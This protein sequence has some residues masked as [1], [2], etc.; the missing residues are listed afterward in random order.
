M[1]MERGI[2]E[3]KANSAKD[4]WE[5]NAHNTHFFEWKLSDSIG[6]FLPDSFEAIGGRDS[7]Y[8][9]HL[10]VIPL[11]H[12]QQEC[13]GRDEDLAYLHLL[14][15]KPDM[16]VAVEG[17]AGIGK[18]TLVKAYLTKNQHLYQHLV[19]IDYQKDL[20]Q[21]FVDDPHLLGLID[22]SER[23]DR[24]KA[25]GFF[26]I[27]KVLNTLS[28]P[29]LLVIDNNDT[30]FF[31]EYKQNLLPT[32]NG[33]KT[34]IISRETAH[35][36]TLKIEELESVPA[37][38]LFHRHYQNTE[39]TKIYELLA[40]A[41]FNPLKIKL[42]AQLLTRFQGWLSAQSLLTLKKI[43]FDSIA[44]YLQNY[45]DQANDAIQI[46]NW[47]A[48]GGEKELIEGAVSRYLD[49]NAEDKA[50]H[51]V[52]SAWLEANGSTKTIKNETQRYLNK[53]AIRIEAGVVLT[54]WLK[55]RGDLDIVL[56]AINKF[57][58]QHAESLYSTKV[59]EQWIMRDKNTEKIVKYLKKHLDKNANKQESF[60]VM[61][62]WLMNEGAPEVVKTYIK[63]YLDLYPTGANTAG[64]IIAWLGAE[65]DPEF[66]QDRLVKQLEQISEP[67]D[68]YLLVSVW[69]LA[70][71]SLNAVRG[72]I[73]TLM[74]LPP[75]ETFTSNMIQSWL[76]AG[77]E[78]KIVE[79]GM[80]S[81]LRKFPTEKET[82]SVISAWLDAGGDPN[83]VSKA[84][85]LYLEKNISQREA[86]LVMISLLK[87]GEPPKSLLG[88]IEAHLKVFPSGEKTNELLKIWI[89]KG[90]KRDI[91]EQIIAQEKK[92]TAQQIRNFVSR[93]ELKQA[94]DLLH[95]FVPS[96]KIDNVILLESKLAYVK[97]TSALL[98][99]N[100]EYIS[101]NKIAYDIL[102]LIDSQEQTTIQRKIYIS[103]SRSDSSY[104]KA[105]VNHLQPLIR[106]KTIYLWYEPSDDPYAIMEDELESS[107]I[108]I[109]LLSAD[110]FTRR[111]LQTE[112]QLAFDRKKL[113]IPIFV[114]PCMVDEKF[115]STQWLPRDGNPISL[116]K[117]KDE[118]WWEIVREILSVI[119]NMS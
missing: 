12:N 117:N 96:A 111:H 23:D 14:L 73:K 102:K 61:V 57:L 98:I 110:F 116:S 70:N 22:P 55:K 53:N 21:S 88:S 43:N 58:D 87:T 2:F 35:L 78:L 15:Q 77:G 113:I 80:I 31:E 95:D 36:N 83:L 50:A 66:V 46:S 67:E 34:I 68:I 28:G 112:A 42:F 1:G 109:F 40:L 49:K 9:H 24:Y 18:T 25:V 10:N 72:S 4:M 29:N 17:E 106:E 107:D 85:K 97:K 30:Y 41:K 8:S 56:S 75:N 45:K 37:Y 90:G 65:G 104:L 100:K 33:W 103:Y 81:Y 91:L 5:L 82:A 69:L 94:L 19:W 115:K 99:D 63:T 52:I 54:N 20:E 62:A 105:L 71:G 6:S 101:I 64:L 13:I 44:S 114:R 119:D 48:S 76:R 7:G 59:I 51:I 39:E 16:M 89:E 92:K 86:Y 93:N 11:L 74:K 60:E 47:L 26:E 32:K 79:V 118:V 3:D 84:S 27:I 108:V 38:D